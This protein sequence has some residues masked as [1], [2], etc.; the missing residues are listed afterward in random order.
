LYRSQDDDKSVSMLAPPIKV[1][2]DSGELRDM[3]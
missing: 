1:Q 2:A 3:I